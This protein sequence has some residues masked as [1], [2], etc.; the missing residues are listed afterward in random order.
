MPARIWLWIGLA[1][2]AIAVGAILLRPAED[3]P[4]IVNNR[5][6]SAAAPG[7][8]ASIPAAALSPGVAAP[9]LEPPPATDPALATDLLALAEARSA[10]VPTTEGGATLDG[11]EAAGE[12]ISFHYRVAINAEE[13]DLVAERDVIAPGVVAYE[14]DDDVC[15]ELDPSIVVGACADAQLSPLIARGAVVRYRY[16]D[17][18][19]RELGAVNV[20]AANC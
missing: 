7:Q 18:A 3:A 20:T 14:C 16:V 17:V 19:D 11:V 2:V 10:A 9:A 15:F 6:P 13:Y 1:I 8:P 5:P 12:E 4:E